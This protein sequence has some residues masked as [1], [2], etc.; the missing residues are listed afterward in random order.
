MHWMLLEGQQECDEVKQDS[1]TETTKLLAGFHRK[2][3]VQQGSS[4]TKERVK[5]RK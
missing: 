3:L 1:F 5:K 2:E 4:K